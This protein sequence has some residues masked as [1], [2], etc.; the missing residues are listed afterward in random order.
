MTPG[1]TSGLV[2]VTP[3]RGR[4]GQKC[5]LT[6]SSLVAIKTW[7]VTVRPRVVFPVLDTKEFRQ[8]LTGLSFSTAP[9]YTAPPPPP[10]RVALFRTNLHLKKDPSVAS[11]SF[12][13]TAPPKTASLPSNMQLVQ[14]MK[15][16]MAMMPA[17]IPALF[18]MNRKFVPTSVEN[19]LAPRAPAAL[20]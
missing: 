17:P 16:S 15:L 8:N 18:E 11:L 9:I 4:L 12:K 13:A 7:S 10:L 1:T 3:V 2:I 20:R 5:T 14:L 19:S 6:A